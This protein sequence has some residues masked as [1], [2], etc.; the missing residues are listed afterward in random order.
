[1]GPLKCSRCRFNSGAVRR[2]PSYTTFAKQFETSAKQ[3]VIGYPYTHFLCIKFDF[4]SESC[5]RNNSSYRLR[6]FGI[7]QCNRN[8]ET[9]WTWLD[10]QQHTRI[11]S[12]EEAE[13]LSETYH[14]PDRAA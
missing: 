7:G 1:M 9:S 12:F 8:V 3:F 14:V 6:K 13:E 2:I 4:V 10:Y 11:V 5:Y